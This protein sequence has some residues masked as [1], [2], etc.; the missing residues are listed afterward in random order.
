MSVPSKIT[1]PT[2]RLEPQQV[3]LLRS[4]Q[5]GQRIKIVQKVRVGARQWEVATSGLFREI[6]YLA[7]GVTTQRVP[8][9]DV[10]IPMVHFTKDNGELSSI[11]LDE[12]TKVEL[13]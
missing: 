9:D 6:N 11:A 2:R 4:L 5:P 10:V 13:A 7:T 8:D 3:E 12:H 1:L